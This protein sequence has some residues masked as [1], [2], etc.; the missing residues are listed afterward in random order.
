MPAIHKDWVDAYFDYGID[1]SNRRLFLLDSIE[2]VPISKIIKGIYYLDSINSEKPIELFIGSNGGDLIELFGLYDVLNTTTCPI[3]TIAV[4]KCM[5]AAPLLV[6]AGKKG[7]RYTMENTTWMVHRL[8]IDLEEIQLTDLNIETALC[9]DIEKR[10]CNL[11]GKHCNVDSTVW[12][13]FMQKKE[14]IYFDSNRAIELGIVDYIWNEK[15]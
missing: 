14:N 7:C 2:E 13:R 1:Y 9:N 11:M 3:H 5:S 10:W 8:S 15:E 4:G 6:A 12:K